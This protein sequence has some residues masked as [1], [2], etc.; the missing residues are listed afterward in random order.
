MII[1]LATA[2]L[3]P[4]TRDSFLEHFNANVP[5]VLQEEGC[6]EYAPTI[7]IPTDIGAQGDTRDDVVVV[8]EK[9][10]SLE[11]L[12]AHIVA[13]HMLEYRAKVKEMVKGT[14]LQILEP[15]I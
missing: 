15:A 11:A 9:W 1:V 5:N 14:T 12:K 7:D 4:G 10:E 6:I 3:V 13:P 2:Q 8:V